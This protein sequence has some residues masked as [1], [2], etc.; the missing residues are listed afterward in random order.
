MS[1]NAAFW[2]EITLPMDGHAKLDQQIMLAGKNILGVRRAASGV[3]V[4]SELQTDSHAAL[5]RKQII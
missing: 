2:A 3:L 5:C 1:G 4:N